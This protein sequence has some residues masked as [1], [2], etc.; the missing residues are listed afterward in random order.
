MHA[1]DEKKVQGYKFFSDPNLRNKTAQ[2]VIS[3]VSTSTRKSSSGS[4]NYK[5]AEVV[6]R[7]HN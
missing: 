5:I 1:T 2:T 6:K 4:G 7:S 3:E